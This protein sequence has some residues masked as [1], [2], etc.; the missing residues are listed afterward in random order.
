MTD[1]SLD[2]LCASVY[3]LHGG[4]APRGA[5]LYVLFEKFGFSAT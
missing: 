2:S 3:A 4:I 5:C 1:L